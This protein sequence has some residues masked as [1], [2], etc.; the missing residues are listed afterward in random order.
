MI[1]AVIAMARD[2]ALAVDSVGLL[3]QAEEESRRTPIPVIAWHWRIRF[4]GAA[5]LDWHPGLVA[6][7]LALRQPP[8]G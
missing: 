8:D 6:S 1:K 3:P 4:D 2:I 7:Y 5:A